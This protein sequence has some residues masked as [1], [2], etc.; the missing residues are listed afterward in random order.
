MTC[1]NCEHLEAE[2]EDV[3]HQNTELTIRIKGLEKELHLARLNNEKA[4]L[5]LKSLSKGF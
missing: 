3:T 2:L 5:V 1:E 4:L